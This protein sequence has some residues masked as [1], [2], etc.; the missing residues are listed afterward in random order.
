MLRVRNVHSLSKVFSTSSSSLSSFRHHSVMKPSF[1][2]TYLPSV[3]TFLT[4]VSIKGFEKFTPKGSQ[5]TEKKTSTTTE[6]EKGTSSN[7]KKEGESKESSS[8]EKNEKNDAASKKQ[9]GDNN[10]GNDGKKG[11]KAS[12][13]GGGMADSGAENWRG[14]IGMGILAAF[15]AYYNNRNDG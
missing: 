5:K 7:N 11:K 2:S 1:L 9:S 6:D 3:H 12:G 8:S 13:G 10:G 4:N 15:L 14:I